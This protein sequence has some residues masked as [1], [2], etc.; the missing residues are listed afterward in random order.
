MGFEPD[1][2]IDNRWTGGN[3]MTKVK[4]VWVIAMVALSPVLLARCG[5]GGGSGDTQTDETA[6][7]PLPD[8]PQDPAA[9]DISG[10]EDGAP[11]TPVDQPADEVADAPADQPADAPSEDAAPVA[12]TV[13]MRDSLFDPPDVTISAGETVAWVNDGSLPHTS[14]SGTGC[15]ADGTW[16]SGTLG[17]GESWSRTFTEAGTYPYYCTFHCAMGM[18]GTVTVT[19]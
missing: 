14:T 9:D 4:K 7:D 13:H 19:P 5:D 10:G 3:T 16:N 2:E 17:N 12:V 15:T 8:N 18:T 1:S 6:G 11:E